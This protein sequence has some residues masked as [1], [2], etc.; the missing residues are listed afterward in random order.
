MDMQNKQNKY[1][2]RVWVDNINLFVIFKLIALRFIYG[3]RDVRYSLMTKLSQRLLKIMKLNSFF[4]FTPVYKSDFEINSCE[5]REIFHKSYR[6]ESY[7]SIAIAEEF[8]KKDRLFDYLDKRYD[9]SKIDLFLKQQIILDIRQFLIITNY[10]KWLKSRE[11]NEYEIKNIV[12]IENNLWKN[13]LLDH[14]KDC[15]FKIYTYPNLKKKIMAIMIPLK[16]F[17]ELISN[18]LLVLLGKGVKAPKNN[19]PMVGV[20]HAQGVDLS[21]K[22]DYF[23]FPDSGIDPRRILVYFKYHCW[24]LTKEKIKFIENYNMQWVNLLPWKL[25]RL[26]IFSASPEFYKMPHPLYIKKL[27]N[28][29]S[30]VFKLLVICFVKAKRVFFWQWL[31]LANL[32]DRVALY[33]AFFS[34]YNVKAHFGLYEAGA[35]MVASNIGMELAGGVDMGSHWSNFDIS[36]LSYGKSH[37]VHFIWGPYYQKHFFEREL[38]NFQYIAFIGYPYDYLFEKCKEKAAPYRQALSKNGAKFIVCFFDQLY[39][40]DKPKANENIKNIYEALLNKVINDPAFGLITKPK[41]IRNFWE[42]PLLE[43]LKPL[44]E[45]AEKTGRCLFLEGSVFTNV[46]SQ[47]AD[48]VIGF[49]VYS[50]PTLEA[51]LS[52]MPAITCDLQDF[53]AHP[54][55]KNGYNSIV[56]NNLDVMMESIEKFRNKTDNKIGDY[57]FILDEIDPFRDGKSSQ[58]IGVFIKWLLEEFD[59]GNNKDLSIVQ[60]LDKYRKEWGSDKVVDFK[61]E[62]DRE[63]HLKSERIEAICHQ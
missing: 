53:S 23:W 48:L 43:S 29:I 8:F 41:K 52:G 27:L 5:E 55:Y 1:S 14:K 15:V 24:P 11:T 21:K 22:T 2:Y 25:P 4:N 44:A 59:K 45:K 3:F 9:R 54:F 56:F 10:I 20:L 61:K 46:A 47:A 18:S 35:D 49:G 50:T 40:L 38:Y 17:F 42:R 16:L 60:V 32:L 7:F 33:E 51:A 62:K 26:R 37:D 19:Q 12:I 28:T 39:H 30:E 34:L 36:F 6:Q 31:H 13:Y 58:R 63:F 57:S